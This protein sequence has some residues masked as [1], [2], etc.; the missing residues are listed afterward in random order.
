MITNM[1]KFKFFN[2]FAWIGVLVLLFTATYQVHGQKYQIIRYGI[3]DG[4]PSPEVYDIAQDTLGRMWFATRYGL[5]VYDGYHWKID[6]LLSD[7]KE[8]QTYHIEVDR[9]GNIWA[10]GHQLYS[11]LHLRKN[12]HWQKIEIP[13][14]LPLTPIP[15]FLAVTYNMQSAPRILI[16]TNTS[17]FLFFENG[18]WKLFRPE[19]H[20]CGQH[21]WQIL[22][23]KHNFYVLGS[24]GLFIFDGSRFLPFKLPDKLKNQKILGFQ[25]VV[26]ST[27]QSVRQYWFLTRDRL[28]VYENQQLKSF[29]SPRRLFGANFAPPFFMV[30]DPVQGIYVGNRFNLVLY[31]RFSREWEDIIDDRK[32]NIVTAYK[33]F[34]DR[35]KNLWIASLHDLY[36]IPSLRYKNF[37]QSDG[38]LENEVST[39]NQFANG[40]MFIGH[41]NGF[42]IFNGKSFK[43]RVI[44]TSEFP[45]ETSFTRSLESYRFAPDSILVACQKIGLL[46]VHSS[47]RFRIIPPPDKTSINCI[48]PLNSKEFLIGTKNG[49]YRFSKNRYTPFL[50]Q[51]TKTYI[52]K[53][54]T[55]PDGTILLATLSN[56]I[57]RITN[58]SKIDTMCSEQLHAGASI[59][60]FLTLP[61]GTILVA[62]EHGVFQIKENRLIPG[63][64]NFKLNLRAFGFLLDRHGNVW[65]GTEDGIFVV[66]KDSTVVHHTYYTGLSGNECNRDALFQDQQGHIWI[67]TVGGLSLYQ[68]NY[69][70]VAPPPI[71]KLLNQPPESHGLFSVDNDNWLVRFY[72]LSFKD[73]KNIAVRYRLKGYEPWQTIPK[74]QEPFISYTRLPSG[75]YQLELQAKNVEGNWSKIVTSKTYIVP[76]PLHKRWYFF[77]IIGLSLLAFAYLV[78]ANILKSQLAKKLEKQVEERTIALK[79]SEEKYRRLFSDSQDCIFITS[80]DGRI[81]DVNPSG[82][83][84]FGYDSYEEVKKLNVLKDIY[85]NPEE[86]ERV[87]EL[88]KKQGYIRNYELDLKRKDGTVIRVMLSST[89]LLDDHG[90]LVGITGFARDVT[91]WYQ[92][93]T[94]LAHKQRME[95]LG[96]LAGG[97]AHDFNNILAG[98]L[99][100]A[101]LMKTNLKP[102][103]KLFRYV[104]IIEKSAQRAADLTQQLLIFSRKGQPK[105]TAV[106]MNT[107]VKESL[108][109]IKS[110][111]PKN[112]EIRLDL[113]KKLPQISADP[114]QLH[115]MIINLAVN[116]RDAI[117][118][119]NGVI[120]FATRAVFIDS[121]EHLNNPDATPGDYVCLTVSDT[122]SGIPEEI[123]NKIFDPFFSTKPKGKGTGMG[124][125]MV[126]GLV[127]NLGGFI[128]LQSEMGKGT[129]FELYFPV[130]DIV[131]SKSETLDKEMTVKMGDEHILVVDDEEMVRNFCEAALKKYG[132]K[133]TLAANGKEAVEIFNK[134][135]NQFQLIVLDMIMPVMDGIKTYQAIRPQ[136][137]K[138]KFLISSGYSDSSKLQSLTDDPLVEVIFKPYRLDELVRKVRELLDKKG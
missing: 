57:L 125:A 84:M 97:I 51:L 44:F 58:H 60:N 59:F 54:I 26:D 114:T 28:Y 61:S 68:P 9:K 52:R 95:S 103:S 91:E 88:L 73:E 132:Y 35:E 128:Q 78:N 100:Y 13:D 3:T 70:F 134:D 131:L 42:T 127:R 46:K 20:P 62:T 33:L 49:L 71:V 121:V 38:L 120:R 55:L 34:L 111:F 109:I 106:D 1:K 102:D 10:I 37:Y 17:A 29:P 89:P 15:L 119:K 86:R 99:G 75:K 104:E 31:N 11:D 107:V 90:N 7:G 48:Y 96:L 87:I 14:N 66:K 118:E 16:G 64:K 98:I 27:N 43:K 39:I 133:I 40:K 12:G 53:I 18:E 50:K 69:D 8:I 67:G 36:K 47:G 76:V 63:Y 116:A 32:N 123:K 4:F 56:G 115:Q 101:S 74:L 94:Q 138:I 81:L 30:T 117:A 110:T 83:A 112:I 24:N 113:E 6:T 137:K 92:M 122:G 130:K 82:L 105:L 77:T 65:I 41:N 80:V 129:T 126:Y 5:C 2:T 22:S 93:K 85:V 135:P 136:N 21:I 25:V 23:N 72:C 79:R 108:K 45:G 124:L 19:G